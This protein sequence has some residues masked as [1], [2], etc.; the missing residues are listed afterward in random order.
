MCEE[1]YANWIFRL[2]V[3][4]INIV[5]VCLLLVVVGGV[6]VCVCVCVCMCVKEQGAARE[7]SAASIFPTPNGCILACV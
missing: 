6:C 7:F 5:F 4:F 3:L 1:L 2:V